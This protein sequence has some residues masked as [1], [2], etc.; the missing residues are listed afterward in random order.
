[1]KRLLNVDERMS[2]KT[3]DALNAIESIGSSTKVL[4]QMTINEVR[5]LA[6]LAAD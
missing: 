5:A 1:M 3:S 4:E 2:S 6:S